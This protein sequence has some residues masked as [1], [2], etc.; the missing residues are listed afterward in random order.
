MATVGQSDAKEKGL[1]VGASSIEITPP[2]GVQLSGA[3]GTHRPAKLVLDPL[4]AKALIL[5]SAGRKM[6]IVSLD[7]TIVTR[8]H[9]ERIRKWAGKELGIDHDA[10]MIH[11][12][13]THSAP[14]LGSFMLSEDF[15]GI[16]PEFEWLRGGDADYDEMVID[17]VLQALE[18]ADRVLEPAEMGCGSGIEGRMAFN[19]RAVMRDGSVT[20]PGR[21]WRDALGPTGI[22]Y[23]EGPIDPELGVLC[24]RTA[25]LRLPALIVNYTCH[26]VHV[27]PRPVVSA[28]WPGALSQ[29]LQAAYGAD[30]TPLVLNG[31]CG[32]VNPWPPFD[33]D[34]REDHRVM[35]RVLAGTV[36]RVVEGLEFR[37]QIPL[38]WKTKHVKIPLREID[39]EDIERARNILNRN[40]RPVWAD[41]NKNQID[42]GWAMAAGLLD[43]NNLRQTAPTHDYEIQIL[44]IGDAALVGLPGEPF[45]EGGLRIKLESPTYPTYI[46]HGVNQY[47][48]YL[49]TGD[50]FSRG[51][52]ETT[53]GNWSR[54]IPEALSIVAEESGRLLRELFP[55]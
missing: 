28:D 37:D 44:R 25:S 21:K 17:R 24:F 50:S 14:S 55:G 45:V 7:L 13:Q 10:I 30:C 16:P 22:R 35:G 11:A 40:P 51:G 23:M 46:V 31:A 38:D 20:M 36:R 5:E 27:F 6:C 1:R 18:R 54:L 32:N 53:T 15:G 41:E 42:P 34:Y 33:P 8:K 3:V 12:T 47:V 9:C 19:R 49:P 4:Y 43:L 39:P 2:R 26:P 29:F 48:G 52:H